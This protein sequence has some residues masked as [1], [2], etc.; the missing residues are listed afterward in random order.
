[1]LITDSDPILSAR[2]TPVELLSYI[3]DG[4]CKGY[5]MSKSTGYKSIRTIT[6]LSE[7]VHSDL[8][9]SRENYLWY[10]RYYKE[11]LDIAE[12]AGMKTC[13]VHLS[14]LNIVQGELFFKNPLKLH[15]PM[16]DNYYYELYNSNRDKYN[17]AKTVYA[18]SKMFLVDMKPHFS[19]FV[20]GIPTWLIDT[21]NVVM[22]TYDKTNRRHIKIERDGNRFRYYTAIISDNWKEIKEVPPDI[23]VIVQYLISNRANLDL[24]H[25]S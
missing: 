19:D 10:S 17:D 16:Y 15:S 18:L 13:R 14:V 8:T 25:E 7:L 22:Y 9:Y 20:K 24:A 3:S 23:D 1:M 2:S 6:D 21:T 11:I 4:I 5:E 12:L